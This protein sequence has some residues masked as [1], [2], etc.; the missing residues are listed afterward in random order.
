GPSAVQCANGVIDV[1]VADEVEA[2][3]TVRRYLSYFQGPLAEWTCADQRLLRHCVPEN[4][5]RAYDVRKVIET[6]ADTGSVLELRRHFA[7]AMVTALIRIEGRPIGLMANNPM[8]L[9]GA[10]DAEAGDKAARFIALCD[11]H[12][13]P[14]LSLCD[15]P[16]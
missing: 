13:L 5:V 2:T 8:H 15:T 1:L 10:I 14:L 3:Q 7:P 9:G 16:G 6:L 12:G 4:R 11:A